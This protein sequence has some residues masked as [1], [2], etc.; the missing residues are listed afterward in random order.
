MRRPL[1]GLLLLVGVGACV[2][3]PIRK[4]ETLG[5][6]ALTVTTDDG[7]D[8]AVFRYPPTATASAQPWFGQPVVLWHGTSVNRFS[9]MTEG[10]D[11]AL[12]LSERGFDVWIPEYRGDR[13]SRG[14][15]RKAYA[16]GEW[17]VDDIARHDVPAVITRVQIES[18]HEQVFWV[19]HSLGGI[20]GYMTMQGPEADAVA[21]LVTIGSPGAWTH[22]QRL[23]DKAMSMHGAVPKYGQVPTRGIAKMLKT[24][25][26]LAPDDPL[27][28]AVYNLDNVDARALVDFVDAGMEN[29]GRGTVAQYLRW[30]ETERITS[31]DGSIDY[32]EGLSGVTVPTLLLAGRVDHIVPPWTVRA[33][34]DRLGSPDKQFQ[35]LG[36]GWGQHHDYGHGDLL[37][38]DWAE[39]EVF[40]L[41]SGWIEARAN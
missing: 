13:T 6:Y 34:F 32:T 19:G 27:L 40:P 39:D 28:H 16:S 11:L 29:I 37:I 7:W 26:N 22:A 1:L 18:K 41:I 23:A 25:V 5:H 30:I 10:S 15:T 36:R 31:A 33:A 8:L 9:Y 14:P 20:L 3:A 24:T 35:V 2:A 17:D 38:G 4:P 21:G 12:H